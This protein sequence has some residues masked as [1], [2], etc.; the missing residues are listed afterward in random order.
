MKWIDNLKE[1]ILK[2]LE[3]LQAK[4]IKY[5]IK[6]KHNES[7]EVTKTIEVSAMFFVVIIVIGV[8][9]WILIR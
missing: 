4:V 9:L 8:V 5:T 2:V 1:A 6:R 7:E 3:F